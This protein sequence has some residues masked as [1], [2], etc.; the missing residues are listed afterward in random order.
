[1]EGGGPS[2]SHKKPCHIQD[3]GQQKGCHMYEIHGPI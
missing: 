1:M 2:S 3:Q